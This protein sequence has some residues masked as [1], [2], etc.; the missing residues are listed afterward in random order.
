MTSFCFCRLPHLV[1]VL[2]QQTDG[3]FGDRSHAGLLSLLLS[4]IQQ[5]R[6]TN[7]P[8]GLFDK[9]EILMREWM[10]LYLSPLGGRDSGRAFSQFVSKMHTAG[11]LKT[12]ELISR[13]FR[14]STEM[15]VDACMRI[16]GDTLTFLTRARAYQAV[17][18]YVRLVSLL[19]KHSGIKDNTLTK[20]N[21]LYKVTT[22]HVMIEAVSSR[23]L[24]CYWVVGAGHRGGSAAE[25][26]GAASE[27]LPADAVPPHPQHALLRAH[28]ARQHLREHADADAHRIQQ[29][30]ARTAP[31][32]GAQLH[33]L[34]AGADGGSHVHRA[35]AHH[36]GTAEHRPG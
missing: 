17:D 26:P 4:G 35:N 28:V 29:R 10:T 5:A 2:R 6:D 7:D 1:E 14:I 18:G 25:G 30:A 32:Q 34:V 33:L 20:V 21:L 12:D 22:P 31:H 23:I 36:P 13:F 27:R 8:S 24:T 3:V 11:M 19:I 9:T 16:A 15:C